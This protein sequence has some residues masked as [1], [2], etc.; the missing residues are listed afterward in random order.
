MCAQLK[1]L[2]KLNIVRTSGYV[3]HST[4]LSKS[5]KEKS[6]DADLSTYEIFS[7]GS[8]GEKGD[9]GEDGI[10]GIEGQK[11]NTGPA[12]PPG[13]EGPRGEAGDRGIDGVEGPKGRWSLQKQRKYNQGVDSN[14]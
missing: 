14:S 6:I 2:A 5:I 10:P 13:P 8:P 7:L 11:G 4:F 3:P 9:P 1:L 12:G